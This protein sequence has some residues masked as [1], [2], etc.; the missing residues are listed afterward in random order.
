MSFIN[1]VDNETNNIHE[2]YRQYKWTVDYERKAYLNCFGT[3]RFNYTHFIFRWN[4]TF[5]DLLADFSTE[6]KI[7]CQAHRELNKESQSINYKVYLPELKNYSNSTLNLFE[8]AIRA[9]GLSGKPMDEVWSVEVMY[10]S[11]IVPDYIPE[12]NF[13]NEKILEDKISE[14]ESNSKTWAIS[15]QQ[16]AMLFSTGNNYNCKTF[17]FYWN[18]EVAST[19]VVEKGGYQ[20]EWDI[21]HICYEVIQLRILPK[22]S[23]KK[24]D[25]LN[26]LEEAIKK[27]GST[28]KV[29]KGSSHLR[30]DNI[31][32]F[33]LPAKFRE[34][35][36]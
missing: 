22:F 34:Q 17:I 12:T 24:D 30:E 19:F 16:N 1:E 20:D 5:S 11:E 25:V 33:N 31:V 6:N 23:D 2:K 15:K 28:G 36:S 27:Y 18:N 35:Q 8:E 32:E 7:D 14:Y 21:F 3:N 10:I 26:M 9:Y 29:G 4:A 13:M